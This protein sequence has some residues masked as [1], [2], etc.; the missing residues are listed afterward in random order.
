MISIALVLILIIGINRV[1]KYTTDTVG[2]QAAVSSAMRD[3]RA[4]ERTMRADYNNM[5]NRTAAPALV[6]QSFQQY[7]YTNHQDEL[8]DADGIVTTD[9]DPYGTAPGG[10]I[11][12][13][14]ATALTDGSNRVPLYL[15]T[16]RRC[17]LD[18]ISFFMSDVAQPYQR[19]T[20]FY[21]SNNG[22]S[23][24]VSNTTSSDAFVSYG[25]LW[26]PDNTGGFSTNTLPGAGTLLVNPNNYYS[27][28]WVLG[29]QVILFK[30][31]TLL[32]TT[33]NTAE[34]YV[35]RNAVLPL[36]PLNG[37]SVV[38]YKTTQLGATQ[39]YPPGST[40][41][42]GDQL[43]Q[44][45]CDVAGTTVSQ[46]HDDV[47]AQWT[48]NPN[49]WYQSLVGPGNPNTLYKRFRADPQGVKPTGGINA[50]SAAL[51]TP[52][53]MPGCSSFIVEFAGD[54]VKQDPTTGAPT[55]ATPDGIV[56]Y[57]I[58]DQG[59]PTERRGIRWYGLP[60]DTG[61]GINDA[62]DGFYGPTK[63]P[64]PLIQSISDVMPVQ[65]FFPFAYPFEKP[66]STIPPA[67]GPYICAW[68][69]DDLTSTTVGHPS[70]IRII[71]R[72]LDT[73]GRL[74]DGQ[75]FEYVFAVK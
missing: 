51:S 40:Q 17:R 63:S 20:G 32:P 14:S 56:D 29:R 1:F 75:N 42:S 73:A 30:D 33:G 57:F 7:A 18:Q 35:L 8:T 52:V 16:V 55:A 64:P 48:A 54:F 3:L 31:A 21:D 9:V 36:S 59:L 43:V 38:N 34:T 10:T 23:I 67:G 4:G 58:I 28:Q 60:R 44:S 69:P 22:T 49:T 26:L 25:H 65:Q 70:M 39:S 72:M 66:T 19:Q 45:L 50:D 71:V 47:K 27:S 11:D 12:F 37:A 46:F 13:S 15:P 24:L 41:A 62:P 6:I 61:G 68:S 53:F 5:V 2:T 74:Q